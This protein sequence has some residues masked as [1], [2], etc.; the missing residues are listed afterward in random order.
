MYAV[1][2]EAVREAYDFFGKQGLVEG[3]R[4]RDGASEPVR[5]ATA[6]DRAS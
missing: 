3:Y 4:A 2:D 6:V 1:A 5:D